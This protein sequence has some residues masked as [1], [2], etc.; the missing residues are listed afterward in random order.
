MRLTL[1]IVDG[2][3]LVQE[4][5]ASS[6]QRVSVGVPEITVE[7]L[8]EQTAQECLARMA[9]MGRTD[10]NLVVLDLVI[11]ETPGQPAM[12][13]TGMRLLKELRARFPWVPVVVLTALEDDDARW[14]SLAAGADG[15]VPKA[16]T[17]TQ[18]VD[19]LRRVLD[20]AG[21]LRLPP[22]V[23]AAPAK[24][25][26]PAEPPPAYALLKQRQLDVLARMCHGET[27]LR[28]ARALGISDKTIKA[29]A[30]ELFKAMRVA[31]RTQAAVLGRRIA[32]LVPRTRSRS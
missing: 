28:I 4:G 32:L 26:A 19:M 23:D 7:V 1:L 3:P 21:T 25:S 24:D 2:H 11:A 10:V 14:G 20:A 30:T 29:H 12:R 27:N 18:L 5:L 17:S 16:V 15:F 8:R 9:R 13:E 22:E 31:N 6:L